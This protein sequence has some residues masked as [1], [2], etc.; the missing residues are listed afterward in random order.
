MTLTKKV[1]ADVMCWLINTGFWNYFDIIEWLPLLHKY[2]Y[3]CADED[4]KVHYMSQRELAKDFDLVLTS[5]EQSTYANEY[6]SDLEALA[7]A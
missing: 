5:E 2:R 6:M 7:Q 4:G 1:K 3:V